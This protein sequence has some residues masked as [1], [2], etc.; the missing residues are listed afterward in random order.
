MKISVVIRNKNEAEALKFLLFV[1]KSRYHN[2]IDEII[3][4][5][6]LSTD[7]S[8]EICQYYDARVVSIEKFSYGGSANIAAAEAKN[9]IVV[10]FSAHSYPVSHDFF[11]LIKNKFLTVG[12]QLAG[13]RCIHNNTD[14]RV[15]LKGIKSVDS[16][17]LG[18]LIFS[19]SAF[20][21]KLWEKHPFNENVR[22]FE[23]K[24]WSKKMLERGYTI[25][26]VPSIFCYYVKRSQK[27]HF[28]RFK[29]DVIGGYQLF[30]KQPT[31]LY[32]LKSFLIFFVRGF[33]ELV[34]AIYY[35]F[36]RT[37]FMLSLKL[38]GFNK[39]DLLE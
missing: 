29:N 19:G 7:D 3:V 38:K 11:S 14:Y 28:F 8:L 2:D 23:D 10:I 15:Y 25:E 24:E 13:V 1:L 22:T 39:H 34:K 35:N 27:Q 5:D 33:V 36:R 6:N 32:I 17:N 26:V 18:G 16:P 30:N 9:D 21:R 37:F 12:D 31:Y 20:S 4:L